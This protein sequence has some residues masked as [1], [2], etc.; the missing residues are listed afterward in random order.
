MSEAK[1]KAGSGFEVGYIAHLARLELGDVET[2]KLQGQLEHILAYVEELGKVD[3]SGV[4][5]MATALN[6]RPMLRLDEVRPTLDHESVMAN[7]PVS[8]H[9]QIMVP[10][11]LE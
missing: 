10:P 11:I 5:P 9:G 3:V 7:A 8:R 1:D 4:A 6:D 2:A